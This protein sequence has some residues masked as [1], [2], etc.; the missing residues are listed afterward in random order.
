MK[1]P[2]ISSAGGGFAALALL[3]AFPVQATDVDSGMC[4]GAYPVPLMT[5]GECETHVAHLR[6]LEA[7]GDKVALAEA[8]R[9]HA[10]LL[11]ARALACGCALM[12]AE[13]AKVGA[14]SDC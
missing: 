2:G 14:S 8:L 11:D 1:V 4:R 9:Q 7:R 6:A 10:L 12:E 3:A 13:P 5:P